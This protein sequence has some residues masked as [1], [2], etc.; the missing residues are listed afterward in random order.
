MG[1]K[2]NRVL[3]TKNINQIQNWCLLIS[4]C[5]FLLNITWICVGPRIISPSKDTGLLTFLERTVIF[6][7][8]TKG[9]HIQ[10][11]LR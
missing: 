5:C 11:E 4:D 1:P 10:V 3:A 2:E 8:L 6:D 7:C 9:S